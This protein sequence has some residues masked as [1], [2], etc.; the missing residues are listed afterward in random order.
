MNTLKPSIL[1]WPVILLSSV[2]TAAEDA[3]W[4]DRIAFKGDL[5][6]RY[7]MIDLEGDDD[8]DRTRFRARFGFTAKASD[9]VKIV[10]RLA[11]G[12]DDPVSTNQTFDDGFSTK[13]IGIDQAYVDWQITDGLNFY[14]GKMKNPLFRA[15]GV[16]L[17]WD[18][19][20]NPEGLA[21]RYKSGMF[22]GNVGAFSVEQ[23]SVGDDSM[24][25][26]AQ[27]GME[28]PLGEETSLTAGVGYFAYTDTIGNL[29]FYN[30]RPKGNT[31]ELLGTA[32]LP[33]GTYLYEY[34]NTELFAELDTQIGAWPL[35]VFVHATQNR[36][37]SVEDAA[38]AFGLTLGSAKNE[39]DIE[40]NYMYAD[41]EADSLIGA[42]SDSDF[43]GGGTDSD[44][45]VLNVTYAISKTI[46]LGGTLFV[47]N[48]NEFQGVERDYSRVQL[49]IEFKFD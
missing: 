15:G 39:G 9:D 32:A 1:L 41:I 24:L 43:G 35:T 36:E 10:V 46:A 34:R 27:A 7:E 20:L 28:F 45:H 47:N 23:R 16:P 33:I 5:R 4:V 6:L 21:L 49:D 3:S 25:Y 30:G 48:V 26:A 8:V 12:G 22:F 29:P 18:S 14:G 31:V 17:V 2:A 19:D 38:F 13:D 42:F 44:G 11:T 40:I 37:V